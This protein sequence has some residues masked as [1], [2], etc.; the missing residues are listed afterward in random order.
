MSGSRRRVEAREAK[1]YHPGPARA[2]QCEGCGRT[3]AE[4]VIG[5]CTCGG[6]IRWK[7]GR[8]GPHDR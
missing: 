8:K 7:A 3:Y 4:W 2:K 5:Y 6:R 1:A